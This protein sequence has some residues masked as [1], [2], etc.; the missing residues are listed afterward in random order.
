MNAIACDSIFYV[1]SPEKIWPALSRLAEDKIVAVDTETTGL[2]PWSDRLVSGQV[3]GGHGVVVMLWPVAGEPMNALRNFL[4]SRDELVFH[5]AAFDLM[6]LKRPW[7][8]F[9]VSRI[10]DS[11][12]AQ[13]VLRAGEEKGRL[14]LAVTA[15]EWLGEVVDK[16]TAAA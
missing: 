4:E 10:F 9:E 12:L 5:N 14:S 3:A 8:G 16:G 6:F 2:D 7:H 13:Y 15:A 1:E 11:L